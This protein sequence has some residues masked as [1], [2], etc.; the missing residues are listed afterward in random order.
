MSE[1]GPRRLAKMA[2]RL[3]GEKKAGVTIA[4]A[5][6]SLYTGECHTQK[7]RPIGTAASCRPPQAPKT[8]HLRESMNAGR[9][10]DF[11]ST[12]ISAAVLHSL[13]LLLIVLCVSR[14]FTSTIVIAGGVVETERLVPSALRARD[15]RYH[16]RMDGRWAVAVDLW[17][18]LGKNGAGRADQR[19]HHPRRC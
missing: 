19:R 13:L 4:P 14:I 7:K 18:N 3:E 6:V 1:R 10:G 12:A 15:R 2:T 8:P 5:K 11:H 16:E 17:K 9:G